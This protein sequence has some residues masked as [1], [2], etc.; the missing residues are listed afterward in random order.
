MSYEFRMGIFHEFTSLEPLLNEG[1]NVEVLFHPEN[2]GK[3]TSGSRVFGHKERAAILIR[4]NG[5]FK[6]SNGL[7]LVGNFNF[8]HADQRPENWQ[9]CGLVNDRN[10]FWCLRGHLAEAVSGDEGPGS[11]LFSDMN[12]NAKHKTSVED[13]SN[14]WGSLQ[15][16]LALDLP[17][18]DK[19]ET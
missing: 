8:I 2:T 11:F 14:G 12:G 19:M 10:I 16:D 18:R 5:C 6:G 7:G 1:G 15:D 4:L 13:H 9:G 17:K 3:V